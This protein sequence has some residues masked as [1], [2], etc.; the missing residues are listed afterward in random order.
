MREG[1]FCTEHPLESVL[2]DDLICLLG[3]FECFVV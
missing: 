1:S 2:E 3:G